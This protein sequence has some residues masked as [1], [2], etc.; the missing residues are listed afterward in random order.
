MTNTP[1]TTRPLSV[2]AT[3]IRQNWNKKNSGTELYFG[4]KPYLD[5]MTSL[6]SIDDNYILDSGRSMVAYF[7]ANATTWRGET[8]RRIKKELNQMLLK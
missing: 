3:K 6:D 8:A 7:L 2:I 4:A 1:K 5:A